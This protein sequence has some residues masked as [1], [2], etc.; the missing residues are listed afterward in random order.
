MVWSKQ[1]HAPC[2]TSSSK[3]LMAVSC[4]QRQLARR[5]RWVSPA[6]HKKEGA[7]QHPGAHKHS[8]QYDGRPDEHIRVQVGTW[9]LGNLSEKDEKCVKN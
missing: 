6:Y 9:R 2:R 7:T 4:C 3:I 1:G 8:L 5:L